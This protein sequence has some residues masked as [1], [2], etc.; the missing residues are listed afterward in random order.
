MLAL[1]RWSDSFE[2]LWPEMATAAGVQLC[3]H[4]P[5][6][7]GLN[8]W[9]AH[10]DAMHLLAAGG[11]ER[12]AITALERIAV[13]S[14]TAVVGSTADHRLAVGAMRQRPRSAFA[15]RVRLS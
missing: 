13:P 9:A 12:D 2:L 1:L 5:T 4:E 11:M 8:A 7:D 14:L 10:N 3:I 6:T 15:T